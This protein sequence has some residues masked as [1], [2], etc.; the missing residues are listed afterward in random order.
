MI[1]ETIMKPSKEQVRNPSKQQ[2]R[3]WLKEQLA[4]HKP[5]PSGEE[6]RRELGWELIIHGRNGMLR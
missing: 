6:I 4:S 2:V 3:E 1:R 5:P